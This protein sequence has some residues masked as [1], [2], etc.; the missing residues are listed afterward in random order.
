MP[1]GIRNPRGTRWWRSDTAFSC[2]RRSQ[3]WGPFRY[4][5]GRRKVLDPTFPQV[6]GL[7]GAICQVS[8]YPRSYL[9]L[10]I[11]DW[12]EDLVSV[13]LKDILIEFPNILRER[14]ARM[15]GDRIF[16]WGMAALVSVIGATPFV[17]PLVGR[18]VNGA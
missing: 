9:P 16:N 18:L 12:R 5:S 11:H 8:D 2:R 7:P 10:A 14:T 3:V 15:R 13:D 4:F 6:G 1:L 17:A